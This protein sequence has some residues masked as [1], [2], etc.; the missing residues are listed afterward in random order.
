MSLDKIQQLSPYPQ[1][2]VG[3]SQ[4]HRETSIEALIP[5]AEQHLL[6]HS[7]ERLSPVRSL[8][9]L[10]RRPHQYNQSLSPPK[11][12]ASAVTM[13]EARGLFEEYGIDRPAG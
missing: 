5:K 1:V 2:Q 13:A 3:K 7:Y 11:T 6:D 12:R 8:R 4:A 9:T 10:C